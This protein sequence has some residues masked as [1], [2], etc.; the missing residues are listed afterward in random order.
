MST[1]SNDT[2]SF[3]GTPHRVFND[4][5]V[6]H[7][8]ESNEKKTENKQPEVIDL[9]IDSEIDSRDNNNA[10]EE[11]RAEIIDLTRGENDSFEIERDQINAIENNTEDVIIPLPVET[12]FEPNN[13]EP[14]NSDY[15]QTY[16]ELF[17]RP[18]YLS[19]SDYDMVHTPMY[20]D[21]PNYS[22]F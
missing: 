14:Q 12:V 17:N 22:P 20:F 5:A 8:D 6:Q 16:E 19:P 11:T 13:I 18:P 10:T 1:Y 7:D 21:Y 3:H 4:D 2:H 15:A 9:T